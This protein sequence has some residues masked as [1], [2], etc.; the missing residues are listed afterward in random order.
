VAGSD[1]KKLEKVCR[2]I[3]RPAIA[4]DRLTVNAQGQVVYS[5]KKPYNDG[6][7]HIVM[8]K[9]EFMERLAALVPRPKVHLARYHGVL[10][11]HYKYRKLIVPNPPLPKI[12]PKQPHEP[13]PKGR[14]RWARLLSRVFNINMEICSECGGSVKI[15]AAIEDPA[16]IRKIL[17]HLG[18]LNRPPT[19]HAAR[20]P[21]Q[22]C[23]D[24]D[25]SQ[26]S[27]FDFE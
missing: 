6:T 10:A 12:E 18:L 17:D 13:A 22:A 20:G 24:D 5:L 21:P 19:I 27:S 15:I 7:T 26:M 9:L 14:I 4:L 25:F 11:P 8:T 3:A 23:Q 1:R 2:Y 16:V